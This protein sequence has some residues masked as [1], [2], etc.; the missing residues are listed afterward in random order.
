MLLGYSVDTQLM[1]EMDT[2]KFNNY[3]ITYFD[4]CLKNIDVA[5]GG[6]CNEYLINGESTTSAGYQ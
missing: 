4:Y 6:V 5:A 1:G 2:E 3:N